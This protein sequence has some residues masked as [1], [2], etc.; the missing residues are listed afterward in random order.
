[1]AGASGRTFPVPLRGSLAAIGH[2]SVGP[3]GPPT[4]LSRTA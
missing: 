2:R 4:G 1:M 3:E